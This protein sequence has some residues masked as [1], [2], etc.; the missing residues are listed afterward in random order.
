[1]IKH[2]PNALTCANLLCGCMGVVAI[3]R[4]P[5]LPIAWFIWAAAFFDFLDGF[6]ARIFNVNT[7][8]G[9]ELDSLADVISFGL[10]P[11]LIMF[12]LIEQNTEYPLLAYFA[13][14]IAICSALRLAIFNIDTTQTD[15]FKGLPTPAN[16]LFISSLPLLSSEYFIWINNQYVLLFITLL[17]SLLLVSRIPLMALKFKRFTWRGN[18]LKFTLLIASILLLVVFKLEA[19][20]LIILFYIFLSL[21]QKETKLT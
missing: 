10:L 3:F 12:H 9:K 16:A 14:L 20:P 8:I 17:F 6:T 1:M 21:F 4:F 2:L 18:G 19:I 7:A 5:E 13:F 11:A 15:S